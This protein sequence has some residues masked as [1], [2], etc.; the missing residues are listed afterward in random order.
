MLFL[1]G[2]LY[3]ERIKASFQ[4]HNQITSELNSK[5]IGTR[6][7]NVFTVYSNYACMCYREGHEENG[8][9]LNYYLL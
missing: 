7:Y 8:K 2:K 9:A 5:N 3:W 1:Y 4:R 6:F